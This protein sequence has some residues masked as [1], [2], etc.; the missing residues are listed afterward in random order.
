MVLVVPLLQ[1]RQQAADLLSTQ[2]FYRHRKSLV[3]LR[4]VWKRGVKTAA[5]TS[6]NDAKSD[7]FGNLGSFPS[8]LCK[9]PSSVWYGGPS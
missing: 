2:R 8:N 4:L 5:D 1:C 9:V 6:A 3:V 7:G